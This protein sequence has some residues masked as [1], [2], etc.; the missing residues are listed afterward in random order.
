MFQKRPIEEYKFLR[1]IGDHG[2]IYQAAVKNYGNNVAVKQLKTEDIQDDSHIDIFRSLNHKNIIAFFD[3]FVDKKYTYIIS[4]Y[5][6]MGSLEYMLE[7][8][9]TPT[10]KILKFYTKSVLLGLD[11]I[12]SQ[13]S[14]NK[15]I[16]QIDE[17]L[18]NSPSKFTTKKPVAFC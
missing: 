15:F 9:G 8:H 13:G 11:H 3:H 16:L 10:E 18:R 5:S 17:L 1:K 4:E 14:E 12:N 2:S 6:G 7:Q